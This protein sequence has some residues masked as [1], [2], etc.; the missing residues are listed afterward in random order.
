[1]NVIFNSADGGVVHLDG[2][3]RIK[4]ELFR[5]TAQQSLAAAIATLQARGSYVE[6]D[7]SGW[8]VWQVPADSVA[9][10]EGADPSS[11]E[12]VMESGQVSAIRPK[13]SFWLHASLS[14]GTISSGGAR[15]LQR[16]DQLDYAAAIK[17]TKDPAS[18]VVTHIPGTDPPLPLTDE[19]SLELIHEG[20]M[21]QYGPFVALTEGQASGSVIIPDRLKDGVYRLDESRLA[22]IGGRRLRLADPAAFEFKVRS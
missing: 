5:P 19:W 17:Q 15:Y 21:D 20:G 2:P 18:A 3:V 8:Q 11:L 7:E 13:L 6:G 14:G 16:G 22:A 1:M 9:E 10:L 12:A 4:G